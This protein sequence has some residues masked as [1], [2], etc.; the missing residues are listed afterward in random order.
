MRLPELAFVA[1]CCLFTTTAAHAQE[2]YLRGGVPG[3]GLGYTQS[4]SPAFGVRG[5]FTTLGSRSVSET[6]EGVN[7]DGRIK[8]DQ[9]GLYGDWFAASNGWRLTAGLSATK[10]SFAGTAVAGASGTVTINNTTVP[11]GPGD[12]YTVEVKYPSVMPYLGLGYGHQADQKGW[13]MIADLGAFIGR[14]TATSTAS[15]SL[16]S[17]LTAAGVNAQAEIDAQTAKVQDSVSKVPF[18]PVLAVGVSY[19]W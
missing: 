3:V 12:S 8:A 16:T 5:E 15:A 7:F 17:K 1:A 18:M 6:R 4:I 2:V 11:F 13:G 19:R 9:A 10:F 14:A